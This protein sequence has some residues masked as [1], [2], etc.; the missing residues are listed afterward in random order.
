MKYVSIK[1]ETHHPSHGP[2]AMQEAIY[3]CNGSWRSSES[4]ISLMDLLTPI[5]FTIM[6]KILRVKLRLY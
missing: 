1:N 5:D 3:Q 4:T 2:K 6:I